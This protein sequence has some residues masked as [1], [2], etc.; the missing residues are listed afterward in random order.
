MSKLLGLMSVS[1]KPNQNTLFIIKLTETKQKRSEKYKI[2]CI[3]I[4]TIN[5]LTAFKFNYNS[6]TKKNIRSA[7]FFSI[8][9]SILRNMSL[10]CLS[11]ES[12]KFALQNIL[13]I[14]LGTNP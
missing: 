2:R 3:Q 9:S 10:T 13:Q 5:T 8:I 6:N 1:G 12:F 4:F 11:D 14:K 7:N